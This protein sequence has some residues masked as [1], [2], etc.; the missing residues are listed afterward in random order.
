[1]AET[2]RLSVINHSEEPLS[3]VLEPWG[4]IYPLPPGAERFV[5]HVDVSPEDYMSVS[6]EPGYIK[7]W[8]EG[9]G[10]TCG[11][12]ELGDAQHGRQSYEP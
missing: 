1:M 9:D 3:L 12:L 6:V 11:R 10:E 5:L 4:E 2:P 8:A 7:V